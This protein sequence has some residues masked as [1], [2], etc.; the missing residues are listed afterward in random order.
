M[1]NKSQ[2]LN[3]NTKDKFKKTNKI[4]NNKTLNYTTNIK[5]LESNNAIKVKIIE[6]N[7]TNLN[8]IKNDKTSYNKNTNIK[9]ILKEDIIGNYTNNI[10]YNKNVS[11][12]YRSNKKLTNN[13]NKQKS[14]ILL[15]KKILFNKSKLNKIT[16]QEVINLYSSNKQKFNS[17]KNNEKYNHDSLFDLLYKEEINIKI[18]ET[19]ETSILN[20]S[21]NLY[22]DKE[23]NVYQ[24]QSNQLAYLLS[25]YYAKT[26][27]YPNTSIKMYNF[28][29]VKI[30]YIIK[31]KFKL[32]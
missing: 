22:T 4:I 26:N 17:N 24:K 2:S 12:I 10:Q 19:K 3:N 14:K 32:L 23:Y 5:S 25:K 7:V 31:I 18:S 29:R 9:D 27:K 28:G 30:E 11:N 16:T 1:Y 20:E 13:F 15:N 6:K 8:I 21:F